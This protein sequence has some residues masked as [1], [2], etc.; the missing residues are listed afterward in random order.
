M[1]GATN[2]HANLIDRSGQVFGR[3]TVVQ[4]DKSNS[5]RVRWLCRCQCGK[6]VSVHSGKLA[7]GHTKSCGCLRIELNEAWNLGRNDL[8]GMIF[9]RLTVMERTWVD[10]PMRWLCGCACGGIK[11]ATTHYLKNSGSASCGCAEREA[12]AARRFVD[13]TGHRFGL[14]VTREHVGFDNKRKALWRCECDC[15]GARTTRGNSLKSGRVVSCG[16][17]AAHPEALMSR[18]ALESSSVKCAQ[19]R[20]RKRDAGGSFTSVDVAA[21]FLRQRGLCAGHGC[22]VKLGSTYHRDHIK[23]LA[24]GGDNSARNIQLLCP[25]CNHKKHAKDPIDWAQEN[26]RLL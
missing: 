25:T 26:G 7:N 18:E 22:G 20:A 12:A 11:V 2:Y 4:R 3:L 10:G 19:R 1:D 6:T 15:G 17:A 21:I 5:G 9:G 14:L 8:C 16:C 23:P 24:L 13:L